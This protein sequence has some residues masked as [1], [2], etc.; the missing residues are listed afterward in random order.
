MKGKIYVNSI[1]FQVQG[2]SGMTILA[3]F[4]KSIQRLSDQ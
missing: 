1:N 2:A 4:H 3:L